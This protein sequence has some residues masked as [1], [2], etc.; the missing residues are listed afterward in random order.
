[1]KNSVRRISSKKSSGI[2]CKRNRLEAYRFIEKHQKD[3]GLRWLLRRVE[4]LP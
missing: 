1:M 2:H 3:F 4:Y